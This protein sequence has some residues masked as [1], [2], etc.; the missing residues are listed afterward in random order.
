MPINKNAL[1]EVQGKPVAPAK[2]PTKKGVMVRLPID[3][4]K[5]VKRI[6]VNEDYSVSEWIEG[7]IRMRL[8]EE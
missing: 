5:Q 6:C 3:L 1:S 4:H 2:D 8:G 7:A